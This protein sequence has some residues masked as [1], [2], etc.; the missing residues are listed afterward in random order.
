MH[1]LDACEKEP[2]RAFEVNALGARNL[3]ELSEDLKFTLVHISTDY[4]FSGDRNTPYVES[5]S[6]RPLNTYGISK[7]AGENYISAIA[8]RHFIVRVSGLYGTNP[9]RAKGGL[10]F[11]Q[12][13]LKLAIEKGQVRVVD[14][15]ILTPTF[16]EDVAYQLVSLLES[17][18]HG[19]YHLTAEGQCSWYEFAREIFK[20]ANVDVQLERASPGEFPN[21]VPRPKFSVLENRGLSDLGI[22]EMPQWQNGLS[23]Y[24]SLIAD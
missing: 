12:L 4:V 1:N 3:G 20:L 10:N 5:D 17:H 23:K 6:T 19:S 7:L 21:K 8:Q 2:G 24:L 14:D 9:C 18:A 13:M 11:V 22:N 15:E 16:T